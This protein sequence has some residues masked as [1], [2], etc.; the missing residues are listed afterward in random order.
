[1][2]TI[3]KPLIWKGMQ[4]AASFQPL[5]Q[6]QHGFIYE[7]VSI[8]IKYIEYTHVCAYGREVK[9]MCACV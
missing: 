3:W 5:Q 4:V 8:E 7:P 1:M 9:A 2:N 6:Q